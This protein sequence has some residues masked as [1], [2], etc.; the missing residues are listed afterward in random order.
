MKLNPKPEKPN[1]DD[2]DGSRRGSRRDSEFAP[3]PN[4]ANSVTA[5]SRFAQEV[6]T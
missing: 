6:T 2:R 4:L 1:L 3:K 5:E